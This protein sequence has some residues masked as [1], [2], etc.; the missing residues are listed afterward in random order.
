M[1]VVTRAEPKVRSL[2]RALAL[3]PVFLF[4]ALL[5][6]SGAARAETPASYM[7]RVANELVAAQRAGGVASYANVLRKHMDVP[8]IGLAALG[9][10]VN[11]SEERRVG[12]ECIPPCR[13]RWSPYH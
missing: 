10:H 3:L 4:A 1:T 2:G 12:K 11:R 9:E 7:Q 6:S 5:S 8:S 13:S